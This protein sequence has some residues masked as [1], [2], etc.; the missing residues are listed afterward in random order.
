MKNTILWLKPTGFVNSL[1][2]IYSN[3]KWGVMGN[4]NLASILWS[5]IKMLIII[6]KYRF[7]A[8]TDVVQPIDSSLLCYCVFCFYESKILMKWRKVKIAVF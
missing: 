2:I 1:F 8:K 6:I 7:Q 5:I 3:L 4:G